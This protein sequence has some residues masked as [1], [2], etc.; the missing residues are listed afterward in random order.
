M[1]EHVSRQCDLRIIMCTCCGANIQ[2]Q[3]AQEHTNVCPKVPVKCEQCGVDLTR[4]VV[5]QHVQTTCENAQV[6]CPLHNL[7]CMST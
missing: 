5:N 7:G 2:A 6:L 1:K 4:D 3:D